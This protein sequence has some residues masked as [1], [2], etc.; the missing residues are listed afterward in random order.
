MV[1]VTSCFPDSRHMSAKPTTRGNSNTASSD[2]S[3]LSHSFTPLAIAPGTGRRMLCHIL[4]PFLSQGKMITLSLLGSLILELE[5]DD[6][7]HCFTTGTWS[8]V[9]ELQRPVILCDF[10]PVDPSLSNSF[11]QH[12]LAG[13]ELPISYDNFFSF[14]TTI[15]PANYVTV[16]IYRG[17]S[18]S[19]TVYI[20]FAQTGGAYNNY[21]V[22]PTSG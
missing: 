15:D 10:I 2:P 16:P 11:A 12:L 22:A 18:R 4:C 8:N 19:K 20:S 17:F 14:D 13:K 9:W 7:D 21:C 6:P 3:T 1:G 5:L